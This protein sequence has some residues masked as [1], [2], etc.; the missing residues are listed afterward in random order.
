MFSSPHTIQMSVQFYRLIKLETTVSS[1]SRRGNLCSTGL[2]SQCSFA[3]QFHIAIRPTPD[4]PHVSRISILKFW[5]FLRAV[6]SGR[7][8]RLPTLTP[9]ET[10]LSRQCSIID[11]TTLQASTVCYTD[12]FTKL[13]VDDVRTTQE[14]QLWASAACYGDSFTFLYADDICTSQLVTGRASLLSYM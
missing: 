11:I 10:W 13:C 6:E 7:R 3:I 5:N 12:S 8:V 4:L 9:S 14:T 1:S 2:H